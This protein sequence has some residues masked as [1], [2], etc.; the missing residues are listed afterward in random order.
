MW[1]PQ[2]PQK[3]IFCHVVEN[4]STVNNNKV[5]GLNVVIVDCMCSLH[6]FMDFL[7]LFLIFMNSSGEGNE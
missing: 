2:A 6:D 4:G 5:T 7:N 1:C 3:Q